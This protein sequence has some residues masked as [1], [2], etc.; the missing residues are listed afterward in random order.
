MLHLITNNEQALGKE[1]QI[2]Q[3]LSLKACRK[4]PEPT[5]RHFFAQRKRRLCM[6]LLN[7]KAAAQALGVSPVTVDR[8]RRSGSLPYRKIG[9]MV[10]FIPADIDD[11]IQRSAVNMVSRTEED[12][13]PKT[14]GQEFSA[15]AS[16]C[17]KKTLD[18]WHDESKAFYKALADFIVRYK[19]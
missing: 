13:G 10:R 11:F 1:V 18:Y 6:I 15:L 5:E 14:E 12:A 9:S 3:G 19:P 8:L 16:L 17:R 7:K 2:S 4:V